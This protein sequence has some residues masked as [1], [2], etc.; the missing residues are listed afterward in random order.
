[1]VIVVIL[2][3]EVMS[4]MGGDYMM[5]LVM[6]IMVMMVIEAVG[7]ELTGFM[8]SVEVMVLMIMM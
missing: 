8:V 7:M 2:M 6:M 4:V 5:T 1:M 3:T